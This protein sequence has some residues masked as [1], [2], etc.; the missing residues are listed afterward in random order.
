MK[1]QLTLQ[2]EK[3]SEVEYNQLRAIEVKKS[4]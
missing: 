1:N 3:A 4:L 2:K